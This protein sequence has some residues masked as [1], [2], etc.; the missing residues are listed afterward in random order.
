MKDIRILNTA[1][2]GNPEST[3]MFRPPD[4]GVELFVFWTGRSDEEKVVEIDWRSRFK[5]IGV[6]YKH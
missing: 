3:H 1:L 4:C 6:T 2:G 5:G